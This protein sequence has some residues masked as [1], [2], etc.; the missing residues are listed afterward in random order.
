MNDYPYG[1]FYCNYCGMQQQSRYC[2]APGPQCP[3]GP[4][5][6]PCPVLPSRTICVHL[7][8]LFSTQTVSISDA[9]QLSSVTVTPPGMYVEPFTVQSITLDTAFTYSAFNFAV[10]PPPAPG[11]ASVISMTMEIPIKMSA[12]DANASS[13]EISGRAF[14]P[15]SVSMVLPPDF[16]TANLEA[17]VTLGEASAVITN[18]A[19]ITLT[20]EYAICFNSFQPEMVALQTGLTAC[21]C[22]G[23]PLVIGSI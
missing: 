20:A 3:A 21:A 10:T 16:N 7:R 1:N 17:L 2:C 9:A 8:T 11:G 5:R 19:E 6:P 23:V 12:L 14:I 15:L 4:P 22:N 18:L 13:I